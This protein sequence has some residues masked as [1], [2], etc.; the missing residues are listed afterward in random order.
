MWL[1]WL[2]LACA[3]PPPPPSIDGT[4]AAD[5]ADAMVRAGQAAGE[6][7]AQAAAIES[8]SLELRQGAERPTAEVL[9]DIRAQLARAQEN[10]QRM[11][12]E[13]DA[14]DAALASGD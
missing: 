14:A 4:A 3:A 10:A 7:A 8:L 6:V 1:P 11:E 12:S 13:L 9:A 5:A 2:W